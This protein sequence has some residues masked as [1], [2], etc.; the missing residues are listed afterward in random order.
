MAVSVLFIAVGGL[1]AWYEN[2]QHHEDWFGRK[3]DNECILVVT[4]T[5]HPVEKTKSYK[6][7]AS[8]DFLIKNDS[9]IKTKGTIILY[10]KKDS[11]I[12]SLTMA[13]GC[14]HKTFTGNKKS[15]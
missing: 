2:I 3:Y 7:N 1:L 10:F 9:C 8:V 11:T 12:S 5:E 14:H 13:P 4:L 15:R 6:A